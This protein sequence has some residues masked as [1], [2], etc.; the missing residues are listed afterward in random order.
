MPME[1]LLVAYIVAFAI[2]HSYTASR[3][4]K[5]LAYR[6]VSEGVYRFLYSVLSV[7]T[8]LPL[9][10]IW[11]YYRWDSPLVYS[12]PY[13]SR[14]ISFAAMAFGAAM[15]LLSLA[16]TD[17]L[18]FL[19][20]KAVLGMEQ[21]KKEKKLITSGVYG[22]VRHPLYLGGMLFFWGN[23]VM[24]LMDLVGSAFVLA[25]LILGSRLEEGKLLEEF[26][27]DYAEYQ[28]RVSAFLPVKWAKNKLGLR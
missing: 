25:Y 18:E 27:E 24:T 16:Q 12:V 13:P 20:V 4:F 8:S 28:S 23:P 10:G 22:F 15:A 14:W 11:L 5:K 19:G 2:V 17:P 21:K 1:A 3:G 26:G 6:Y 7:L 9:A